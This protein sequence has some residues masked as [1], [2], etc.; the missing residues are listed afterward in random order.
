MIQSSDWWRYSDKITIYHKIFYN[1]WH[2]RLS[3]NFWYNEGSWMWNFARI[4]STKGSICSLPI[5]EISI[6]HALLLYIF[7]F[8]S[9]VFP[10]NCELGSDHDK[11]SISHGTGSRVR[12]VL[13]PAAHGGSL[14]RNSTNIFWKASGICG[15][16]IFRMLYV[17]KSR[18]EPRKVPCMVDIS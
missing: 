6:Y 5:I 9:L 10:F 17:R 14:R 8:I 3:A 11:V 13:S 16:I 15:R 18:K 7:F 4:N 12:N 1:D 2:L